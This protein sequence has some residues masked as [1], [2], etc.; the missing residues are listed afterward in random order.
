MCVGVCVYV[1]VFC[2]MTVFICVCTCVCSCMHSGFVVLMSYMNITLFLSTD[3]LLVA[4][5][6]CTGFI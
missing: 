5:V 4:F 6:K 2:Q 1:G 3:C